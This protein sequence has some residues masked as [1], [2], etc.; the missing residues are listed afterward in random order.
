MWLYAPVTSPMLA[1]SNGARRRSGVLKLNIP[2][3]LS[4]AVGL[5]LI[6]ALSEGRSRRFVTVA[7]IFGWNAGD[8]GVGHTVVKMGENMGH[9]KVLLFWL[10]GSSTT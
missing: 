2:A 5:T 8:F 7:N 3:V 9:G 1:G 4:G 6:P 10:L